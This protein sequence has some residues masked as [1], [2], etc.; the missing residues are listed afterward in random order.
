MIRR[1]ENGM[2]VALL[3]L[4]VL[5]S[6]G[7][8]QEPPV[9]TTPQPRALE[10]SVPTPQNLSIYGPYTIAELLDSIW[11]DTLRV[12]HG[13]NSIYYHHIASLA[14]FIDSTQNDT[15]GLFPARAFDKIQ[16][17]QANDFLADQGYDAYFGKPVELSSAQSATLLGLIRDPLSFSWGECGTWTPTARFEFK[18]ND[19]VVGLLND[20]CVGQFRTTDPRMKF[21]GLT[22]KSMKAYHALLNELEIKAE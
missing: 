4:A 9:Q 6:C 12:A 1:S 8:G 10:D 3:S 20:G 2:L 18:L 17:R 16:V 19:Q 7:Q 14:H 22:G 21:G 11:S 13:R 15:A 5:Q